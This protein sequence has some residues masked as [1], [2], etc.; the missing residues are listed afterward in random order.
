MAEIYYG[1]NYARQ[2]LGR[3]TSVNTSEV[4]IIA[5]ETTD[6]K[7][8][9]VVNNAPEELDT[10]GEVADAIKENANSIVQINT[11]L[12]EW[13]DNEDW[14]AMDNFEVNSLINSI[15]A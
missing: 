15:F 4:K 10:L 2:F 11:R 1:K 7:I 5:E 9:E 12:N 3:E 8:K 14:D 6:E 13:E